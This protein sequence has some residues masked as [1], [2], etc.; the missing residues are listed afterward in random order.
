MAPDGENLDIDSFDG[1]SE[2]VTAAQAAAVLGISERHL[3]RRCVNG[4]LLSQRDDLGRWFVAS[5]VLPLVP[6][7][8]VSGH[9]LDTSGPMASDGEFH[10]LELF[11]LRSEVA[12][13]RLRAEASDRERDYARAE[14]AQAKR[15]NVA[16]LE[17]LSVVGEAANAQPA[18]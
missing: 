12:Q 3:R 10:E 1:A 5:S 4:S 7:T 6:E 11:A 18:S 15:M 2:W 14:L 16:Y 9:R 17:A 8:P 13:L